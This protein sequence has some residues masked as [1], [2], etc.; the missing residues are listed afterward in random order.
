MDNVI[1]D[2]SLGLVLIYLL[3]ALLVTQLQEL[4]AGQMR[5]GR[6]HYLHKQLLEAV[7][8]DQTLKARVLAHP[9]IFA[10]YQGDT[11]ARER[12]DWTTFMTAQG[13]SAIPPDLFAK[14][15]LAALYNDPAGH[16]PNTRHTPASFVQ[17][18]A[19]GPADRIGGV[20]RT[21]L[22]GHE[23][24]WP[25]FEQAVADWYK[26]IGDRADGWY[27]RSASTWSFCLA[28]G[29]AA[30]L[31]ADSF[32]IATRLA[33][34]PVLRNAMSSL[35]QRV[36]A[37]RLQEQ[38]EQRGEQVAD[39]AVPP[40]LP[41]DR[42]AE[43]SLNKAAAL[44]TTVY[45]RD[46]EVA[47]LDLNVA[48]LE[49]EG[50]MV[51]ACAHAKYTTSNVL[52]ANRSPTTQVFISNPIN[53]LYLMPLLSAQIKMDRA[54][55]EAVPA[56]AKADGLSNSLLPATLRQVHDCLAKLAPWVALAAQRPG[57]DPASQQS[58]RD[59]STELSRAA[60]ALLEALQERAAPMSMRLLFQ[61][62]P[63]AF[64]TC[65]RDPG[66]TRETLKRC[67]MEAR[68][69]LLELPLGWSEVNTRLA[70]CRP[71]AIT[72]GAA[73]VVSHWA[74]RVCG[75]ESVRTF[76]GN[77]A[78]GLP[79]I[80]LVGPGLWD[81]LAFLAGV[82]LTAIFVSLGAPFW[83]DVLSRVVKLRAAGSRSRDDALTT[84]AGS[85]PPADKKTDTPTTEPFSPARNEL[86]RL[87]TAND[88]IALQG[89]LG[90]P[91]T[92]QWDRATRQRLAQ[93]NQQGGHG[94]GEELSLQL[95]QALLKRQPAGLASLQPPPSTG[96]RL[97]TDDARCAAAG[98]ALMTLLDF[99]GRLPAGNTRM[100]DDLRALAVLWRY[101]RL[102]KNGGASAALPLPPEFGRP[103]AMDEITAQEFNDILTQA[104]SSPQP[105]YPRSTARWLDWALGELGQFEAGPAAQT[106]E[107]SNPRIVDYL[108]AGGL[109]Q[110]AE[111]TSW[112]A[113]FVSWVLSQH[114]RTVSGGQP[115]SISLAAE[116]THLSRKFAATA[117]WLGGADATWP[118]AAGQVQAGDVITFRQ[119]PGGPIDHVGFVVALDQAGAW[120]VSGN[121][122]D[123]VG[124]D[125]FPMRLVEAICRPHN[126]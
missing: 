82:L 88:V 4:L 16:P 36:N 18:L 70:F 51:T 109:Q 55:K 105:L 114:A 112:C 65:S 72:P 75:E 15:L 24:H 68:R 66:A 64:N 53:W 76:P 52:P 41:A 79:A 14:A 45:F 63:D 120:V 44:L 33:N 123:R 12:G 13:P 126:A 98:Q 124:L 56:G 116:F 50:S 48:K 35:A 7:G 31:N 121:F 42:R 104:A 47:N 71:V 28:L 20:L 2:V 43:Q 58:L 108:A 91:R 61:L 8:H 96:L 102:V 54:Q 122:S 60:D 103:R 1:L 32:Q 49:G 39:G 59:A 9:A 100:S 118:P 38:A 94:S 80:V 111:S 85:P 78:L 26:A 89:A 77:P 93:E 10:L 11:P 97:H 17:T 90:V 67:V 99:P 110:M 30:L 34:E 21:L 40:P 74:D 5:A 115:V 92:G 107:P 101:K 6:T 19:S 25:G 119:R 113:C 29:L 125:H 106:L 95:Y 83:F 46:P 62:D 87:L 73:M 22:P 27:R 117:V 84:P 23:G 81:L 57:K 37:L 69:G 86:E 3:M